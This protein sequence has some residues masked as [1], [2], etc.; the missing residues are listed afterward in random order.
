M[1]INIYI[2][3]LKYRFLYCLYGG[4]LCFLLVYNY[5]K[6][7]FYLMAEPFCKLYGSGFFLSLN[8]FELLYVYIKISLMMG[9]TYII[10]C[11]I[12]QVYLFL[13][14]TIYKQM[15]NKVRQLLY[16]N[17]FIVIGIFIFIYKIGLPLIFMFVINLLSINFSGDY[18]LILEPQVLNYINIIIN[19]ILLY[20]MI[21]YIPI[22]ILCILNLFKITLINQIRYRL[23]LYF[24]IIIGILFLFPPDMFLHI[25]L[26]S[27]IFILIELVIMIYL[28]L[29]NYKIYLKKEK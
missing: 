19:L 27:I 12:V 4:L 18:N 13:K 7:V 1:V 3:E 8:L 21:I 25:M 22:L 26:F 14:P 2:K 29:Y 28:L 10:F 15:N 17:I 16:L 20:Y 6:E 11:S 23:C 5:S 9:F 24:L